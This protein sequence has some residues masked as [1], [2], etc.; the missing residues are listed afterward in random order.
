MK[1][2]DFYDNLPKTRRERI[3]DWFLD[4]KNISFIRYLRKKI[5]LR[6]T[7]VAFILL[8]C[9]L[10][11]VL[12]GLTSPKRVTFKAEQLETEKSFA[13]DSGDMEL[14][15]QRYSKENG[16]AVLEFETRPVLLKRVSRAT[17]WSG[18]YFS[19]RISML[20]MLKCK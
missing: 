6:K 7:L 2:N 18:N 3:I 4:L 14:V 20:K 1:E 16:I 17:I 8:T 11:L 12:N 15:S 5:L 10:L 13:N 19:H 9:C